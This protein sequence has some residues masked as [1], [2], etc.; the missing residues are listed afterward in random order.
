MSWRV[1][2][3]IGFSLAAVAAGH[4]G[5][6]SPDAATAAIVER[7]GRYVEAY[8]KEFSGLICEEQQHQTLIRPD[9]RVH[10]QRDLKSDLLMVK[11]GDRWLQQVFRDVIEVD[12]KPVRNRSDR[13]RK[14]FLEGSKTA[15]QQATAIAK[16]SGRYNIGIS[17]NGNSPLLPIFVLDPHLAPR[18]RFVLSGTSL[19]FTE[20]SSP[21]FLHYSERGVLHDFMSHGSFEIDP[22]TGRILGAELSAET[23][24]VETSISVR[25]HED[26]QLKLFVPTDLQERYRLPDRPRDDRVEV[27]STYSAFRRFTVIVSE[28]IKTPR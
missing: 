15:M 24:K 9:G 14:L 3:A 18:F 25:Y 27:A 4:A 22:A 13:L 17:R 19:A 28:E 20:F 10:D 5:T 7:A 6:Q 21:S 2:C 1:S 12:G 16:E 11:V 26:P 8:E 23:P